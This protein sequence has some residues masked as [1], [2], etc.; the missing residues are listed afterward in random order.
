MESDK[1]YTGVG[2][3]DTPDFV[4]EAFT[5]IARFLEEDSY[6]LRS[7]HADGADT[8]FENGVKNPANKQIWLP[9]AGW[10]GSDSPHFTVLPEAVEM[11][12]KIHPDWSAMK[13]FGHAAHSRNC[14][15]VLGP[16]LDD[17][18]NFLLCWTEGA[19][20]KGGTRTAIILAQNH[21]VP[22]INF[23]L[24]SSRQHVM[25]VFQRFYIVYG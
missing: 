16:N 18:S 14:H 19:M 5:E 11:A 12:K 9:K 7:G 8:G 25:D 24:C 3:R 10:R 22:L 2:S 23:G 15:Q 6:K 17:P 1:W 4:C 20:K 13:E 21:K